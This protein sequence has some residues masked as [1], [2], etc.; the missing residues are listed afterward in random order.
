M[1]RYQFSNKK[2]KKKKWLSLCYLHETCTFQSKSQNNFNGNNTASLVFG[3]C[4]CMI[5]WA[6]A[7]CSPLD[8]HNMYEA[9]TEGPA[10]QRC[11][12]VNEAIACS[13]EYVWLWIIAVAYGEHVFIS[14]FA[15]FQH[16]TTNVNISPRK[17]E[18]N[19]IVLWKKKK[20]P[21][22]GE[23]RCFLL[24]LLKVLLKRY[25]VLSSMRMTTQRSI[26][27]MYVFVFQCIFGW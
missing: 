3:R 22:F 4:A 5:C 19:N 12:P 24:L 6:V 16:T 17:Y 27:Y 10:R 1:L 13:D 9:W 7:S 15:H 2:K 25:F 18:N 20:I 14:Y 26:K 21:I 11:S 23:I 8:I